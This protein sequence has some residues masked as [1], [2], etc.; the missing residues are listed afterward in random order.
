MGGDG[1]RAG[2]SW[3]VWSGGS[4]VCGW[5]LVGDSECGILGTFDLQL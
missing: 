4:F 1:A 3:Y 2:I 5:K